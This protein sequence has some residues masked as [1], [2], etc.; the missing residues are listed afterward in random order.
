MPQL[1]YQLSEGRGHIFFL[2]GEYIFFIFLSL[3]LYQP[4][5]DKGNVYQD[6]W[7][8]LNPNPCEIWAEDISPAGPHLPAF[9]SAL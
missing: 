9:L 5:K 1:G 2:G 4:D 7:S 6:C 8:E 3:T